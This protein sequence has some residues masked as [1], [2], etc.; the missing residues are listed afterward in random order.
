MKLMANIKKSKHG[1][2]L[3]ILSWT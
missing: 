1:C 2:P 3:A